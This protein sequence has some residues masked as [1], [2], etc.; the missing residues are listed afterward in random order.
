MT[1]FVENRDLQSEKMCSL[2]L[3]LFET[4]YETA[5]CRISRLVLV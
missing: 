2:D 4:T 3:K 1:R 5:Q